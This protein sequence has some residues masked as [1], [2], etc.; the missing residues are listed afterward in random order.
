MLDDLKLG[1][2]S[3]GKAATFEDIEELLL[4]H[5]PAIDEDLLPVGL[6]VVC[7]AHDQVVSFEWD[8]AGQVVQGHFNEVGVLV[9]SRTT[10]RTGRRI[11]RWL[12]T[13]GEPLVQE[14]ALLLLLVAVLADVAFFALCC[15]GSTSFSYPASADKTA[16]V[17]PAAS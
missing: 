5:G 13:L 9:N 10:V 16:T 14:L 11:A 1:V 4:L 15:R 12:R 7:L 17:T 3:Q 8:L 2:A 6:G